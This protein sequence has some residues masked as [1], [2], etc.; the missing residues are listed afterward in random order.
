MLRLP[1]ELAIEILRH[2][3]LKDLLQC[4]AVCGRLRDTI[5]NSV[6]L[7]YKIELAA[8]GLTDGIRCSLSTAERLAR[9]LE[10]RAR[11]R[12][13]DWAQVAPISVPAVCQAHDMVDGV[14]AVSKYDDGSAHSRHFSLT[15]LPALGG[16]PGRTIE[17]DDVGLEI[18]E[19]AL[20][21]SQDLVAVVTVAVEDDASSWTINL[22]TIS[23]NQPHP[24]AKGSLRARASVHLSN[25]AIHICD[26][27][28]G[29]FARDESAP[30]L[31]IWHWHSGMRLDC[32]GL[33]LPYRVS[34]FNF[35]SNR[36]FML[37]V[38][39]GSG[40][41][42]ICAFSAE[43]AETDPTSPD[44]LSPRPVHFTTV[45]R[46]LLPSTVP[47]KF[48]YSIMT[49]SAPFVAHP[50]P[51]RP[52]ETA[53]GTRIHFATLQYSFWERF[54]LFFHNRL[55]ESFLPRDTGDTPTVQREY[56]WNEWG[57]SNTRFTH[58]LGIHRWPRFIHG[59]RIIGP[60]FSPHGPSINQIQV[61]DFNVHPKRHNDP[62][63]YIP[64]PNGRSY[65][66]VDSESTI[67][68]STFLDPVSTSLP[69]AVS[70]RDDVHT[71]L[72]NYTGFMIDREQI[73]G[74]RMRTK[75]GETGHRMDRA[76]VCYSVDPASSEDR[77]TLPNPAPTLGLVLD[78][79][80]LLHQSNNSNSQI[81]TTTTTASTTHIPGIMTDILLTI[82]GVSAHHILADS[83][84]TLGAGDLNIVSGSTAE[85]VL[86]LTVGSAGFSLHKG[87]PFGT[88]EGE[89]RAY[90]FT[91]E[92]QGI[93]GGFVKLT[94]PE[95]VT[96]DGSR[97]SELQTKF[98]EVLIEHGLLQPGGGEGPRAT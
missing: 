63:A 31:I 14:Y 8:D 49:H 85:K 4:T 17:R 93:T 18:S 9:L 82:P 25:G 70:V 44:L 87:T 55:L 97:L 79:A 57:P 39:D 80:K 67:F 30:R 51:D 35:I 48:V 73:I 29:M 54:S 20:D 76:N 32:V 61:L 86:V 42:E 62:V 69:Y 56:Q 94:L 96:E 34:A 24:Q 81:S 89:P 47:E 90:V 83:D 78:D 37:A 22:R 53:R 50:I 98:E 74:L 27:V 2:L 46:L 23:N 38:A 66:V 95:G 64:V 75:R 58:P 15:W 7:Q 28:I 77:L 68:S 88:L 65:T 33:D 52:F 71:E 92:I 11:W 1:E 6:D 40:R 72:R 60:N 3:D 91:P 19:F 59:A 36:A 21:P 16:E 45:T 10:L 26:D 5:A 12:Y 13:L 41:I 84:V 43:N